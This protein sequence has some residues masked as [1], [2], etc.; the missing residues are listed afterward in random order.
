MTLL[1]G[2]VEWGNPSEAHSIAVWGRNLKN[3]DY[4]VNVEQVANL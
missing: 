3:E 1:N 4:K 2:S